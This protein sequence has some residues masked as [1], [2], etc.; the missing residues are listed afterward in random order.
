MWPV[1]VG[2]LGCVAVQRVATPAE[3]VPAVMHAV[4]HAITPVH[5]RV[6]ETVG[7]RPVDALVVPGRARDRRLLVIG[8]VH[9]S[10]QG[11]IEVVERLRAKLK[12]GGSPR[13]TTVVIPTMFPDHA[14]LRRREDPEMPTNRNFPS[15]GTTWSADD[16]VDAEGRPALRENRWLVGLVDALRPERIVSVH[17][18]VRVEAAGVFADPHVWPDD[19]PRA[20][21]RTAADAALALRIAQTIA[22][23]EPALVAGN[24]LDGTPTAIWSGGVHGG[25]SLGRWAPH[26]VPGTRESIGV[27]T[28]EVPGNHRSDDRTG[29][30]RAQRR[31]DLDAFAD[32]LLRYVLSQEPR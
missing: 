9:G 24:Q 16:A 5:V 17:G 20:E 15:P 28:V 10:E 22:E 19:A 8:G 3:G 32:A 25:V 29:P 2:W 21:A 30:A 1:V 27:L 12:S 14:A 7:G 11:G 26:P 13:P 6:G 31:R 23:V 4:D 18:T